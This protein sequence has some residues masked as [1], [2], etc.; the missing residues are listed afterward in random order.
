LAVIAARQ[1]G[2]A[3]RRLERSGRAC[4]SRQRN[5]PVGGELAI[6]PQETPEPPVIAVIQLAPQLHPGQFPVTAMNALAFNPR[7]SLATLWFR[8][9]PTS[10]TCHAAIGV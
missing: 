5:D 10:H 6:V 2:I 1:P 4:P 9:E 8:L 3:V 7:Y